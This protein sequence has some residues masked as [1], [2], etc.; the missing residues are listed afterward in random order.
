MRDPIARI[1]RGR[2]GG[3]CEY[4]HM[5]E[6]HVSS[7]FEIEHIV[8]KQH[9]G[10]DAL[11]NLAWACAQCNRHK[12]PNLSG[13][14]H[15]VSRIR[16]IRLFHPRLHV[17]RYHFKCSGPLLAGRTAIGRATVHVLNMNDDMQAELRRQ[18]LNEDL[19]PPT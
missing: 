7:Q 9:L 16:P 14:D 17:W 8:P 6:A 5:P 10:S 2:A 19:F 3:R 13:L 15:R 11:G 12:G 1:V 18:L 4:C